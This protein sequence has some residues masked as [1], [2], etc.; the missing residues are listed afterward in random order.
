MN[1]K[2]AALAIAISS[3]FGS[4]L[5]TPQSNAYA[6]VSLVAYGY[7]VSATGNRGSDTI[8]CVALF[9]FCLLDQ[10][11]DGAANVTKEDLA[12]NGYGSAEIEQIVAGQSAVVNHLAANNLRI[13]EEGS[14]SFNQVLS[15]VSKVPG[16][17]P[18]YV[19]FVRETH[20][21]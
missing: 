3:V 18:E 2:I 17:T 9:P 1:K 7:V 4:L 16:V 13:T 10:K 6:L 5:Y 15:F 20:G 14:L 11:M 12:R 19:Q 21:N 8:F